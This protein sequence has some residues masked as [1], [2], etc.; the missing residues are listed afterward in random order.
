MSEPIQNCPVCGHKSVCVSTRIGFRPMCD[1][2]K[3]PCLIGTPM[4]TEAEAIAVWNQICDWK[5]AYEA[6]GRLTEALKLMCSVFPVRDG[7]PN[8]DMHIETLAHEKA[9]AALR[10]AGVKL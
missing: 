5:K 10:E 4:E 9:Q 8:A 3:Y 7:E 1:A 2:A 6:Q